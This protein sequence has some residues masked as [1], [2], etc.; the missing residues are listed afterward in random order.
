MTAISFTCKA[1]ALLVGFP[2]IYVSLFFTTSDDGRV[3]NWLVDLWVRVESVSVSNKA[4]VFFNE[5][6]TL[7]NRFLDKIFGA[8]LMSIQ[9]AVVSAGLSSASL[10]F[11]AAFRFLHSGGATGFLIWSL[12][13]LTLV[14]AV[15]VKP[16]IGTLNLV[17][18]LIVVA[19]LWAN[20]PDQRSTRYAFAGTFV[21]VV[22]DCFFIAGCR[23]LLCTVEGEREI[24]Q[25]MPKLILSLVC[26]AI[27]SAPSVLFVWNRLWCF[28]LGGILAKHPID[29]AILWTFAV[30]SSTNLFA[31]LCVWSIF[32]VAVIALLHRL[33]WPL[34]GRLINVV[35][36]RRVVE[37]RVFL[38]TTGS[39]LVSYSTDWFSWLRHLPH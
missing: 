12:V 28:L 25:I 7:I 32:I 36:E 29:F 13:F 19:L 16:T 3:Q 8:R 20:P 22:L 14:A 37:N 39:M 1:A 9:F 17:V 24:R 21:G 26:G 4:I 33:F 10:Y 15:I 34:T 30:A 31:G 6:A 38:F 5:I 11:L 27:L 18:I 23:K 35:Y 2:L